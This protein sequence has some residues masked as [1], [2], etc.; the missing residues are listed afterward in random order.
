VGHR[1][2]LSFERGGKMK[3]TLIQ[4]KSGKG[5]CFHKDGSQLSI[6]KS[7]SGKVAIKLESVA[8][9]QEAEISF[10]P[11]ELFHLTWEMENVGEHGGRHIVVRGYWIDEPEKIFEEECL[12]GDFRMTTRVVEEDFAYLL[13]ESEEEILGDHG[14]YVILEYWFGTTDQKS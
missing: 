11:E 12:I 1:W 14:N 2:L 6:V 13:F 3:R 7:E 10:T 4:N 8:T 9:T 5:I